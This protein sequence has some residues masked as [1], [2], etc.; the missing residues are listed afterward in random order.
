MQY[1][2]L[3]IWVLITY[4]ALG[5][6]VVCGLCAFTGIINFNPNSEDDEDESIIPTPSNSTSASTSADADKQDDSPLLREQR[7]SRDQGKV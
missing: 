2:G 7:R 4:F 1:T 5:S 3:F 6:I